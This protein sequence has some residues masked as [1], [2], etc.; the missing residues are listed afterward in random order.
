[1]ER[2]L[3][4][5]PVTATTSKE[6]HTK[7]QS[8]QTT[9][10]DELQL[11]VPGLLPIFIDV[12]GISIVLPLVA[13]YVAT[14]GERVEWAGAILTGN[15]LGQMVGT[16]ALGYVADRF[17]PKRALLVSMVGN[18]IF[19]TASAFT[20][21]MPALVAVRFLGALANAVGGGQKWIVDATTPTHR[22]R[23]LAGSMICILM[24]FLVGAG[25][26]GAT[27]SWLISCLVTAAMSV[28]A[29]IVLIFLKEPRSDEDR[30]TARAEQ[31]RL[32]KAGESISPNRVFKSMGFWL[33]VV[34]ASGCG[35]L[36]GSVTTLAGIVLVNTYRVWAGRAVGGGREGVEGV[37]SHP[38]PRT[39]RAD[40]GHRREHQLLHW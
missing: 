13:V 30:A 31:A 35:L 6:V 11:A 36:F 26:G 5:V 8:Q 17:G 28:V 14:L 32:K 34:V 16:P 18:A 27:G 22:E 7:A 38:A 33:S 24:G 37:H 25:I 2:E 39:R 4:A 15:F 3:G 1:M 23:V 40:R 21:N 12:M 9:F 19:F 20:T 10:W 29:G